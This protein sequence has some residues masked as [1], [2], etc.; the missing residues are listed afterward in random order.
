[1][2]NPNL[3]SL[4]DVTIWVDSGLRHPKSLSEMLRR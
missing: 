2:S 3:G 1:L 4:I